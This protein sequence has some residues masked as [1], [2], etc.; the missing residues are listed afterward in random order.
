VHRAKKREKE[1]LRL[2]R[3]KAREE[4]KEKK[5]LEKE[6]RELERKQQRAEIQQLKQEAK[7][8]AAAKG[9]EA[10]QPQ[11]DESVRP[12]LG[13]VHKGKVAGMVAKPPG[14]DA[15]FPPASAV[16]DFL[17]VFMFLRCSRFPKID[18]RARFHS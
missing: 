6:A 16:Q 11:L 8:L 1:E 3:E 14:T 17:P 10:K 4:E 13:G 15:S 12:C 9:E 5:R 18:A 7:E 2:A